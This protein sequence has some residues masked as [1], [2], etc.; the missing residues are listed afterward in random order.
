MTSRHSRLPPSVIDRSAAVLLAHLAR[1][2]HRRR[3]PY[4]DVATAASREH[5]EEDDGYVLVH[6]SPF[7]FGRR[8]APELRELTSKRRI[9]AARSARCDT[10]LTSAATPRWFTCVAPVDCVVSQP[11]SPAL[12][13][14][15]GVQWRRIAPAD[16]KRAPDGE[17][18]PLIRGPRFE[19]GRSLLP[20]SCPCRTGA[21]T[22][23]RRARGVRRR[24]VTDDRA[25]ASGAL[26]GV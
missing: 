24:P 14:T 4:C 20:P 13:A 22:P 17:V 11:I 1:R 2:I 15:F 16:A 19:P 6:G 18:D 7:R 12:P 5:E 25:I 23:L 21:G 3:R 9:R 10:I 8:A 26:G